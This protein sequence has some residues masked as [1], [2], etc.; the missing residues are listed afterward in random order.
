V[1]Q[2]NAECSTTTCNNNDRGLHIPQLKAGTVLFQQKHYV[3]N[4]SLN[5]GKELGSR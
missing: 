3:K 4:T 2:K 1:I 5:P